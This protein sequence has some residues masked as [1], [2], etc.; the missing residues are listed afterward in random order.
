[1]K[2]LKLKDFKELLGAWSSEYII[3]GDPPKKF[4]KLTEKKLEQIYVETVLPLWRGMPSSFHGIDWKQTGNYISICKF[5]DLCDKPM[6][7][8]Y[9]AGL[10]LQAGW[11][12]N[13]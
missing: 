2:I 9:P 3:F 5:A 8:L 1:M 4:V 13:K 12:P 6:W 7:K 11:L 10:A